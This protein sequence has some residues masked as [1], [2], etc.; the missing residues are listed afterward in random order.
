MDIRAYTLR[1][2]TDT[3]AKAPY[4]FRVIPNGVANTNDIVADLLKRIAGTDGRI[5]MIVGETLKVAIEHCR[6]GETVD[7]G[8][9]RMKPRITGSTPFEDSPFDSGLNEFIL[10]VYIDDEL[11]DTFDG[12]VPSVIS[13]REIGG[14]VKVSNVMD[15]GTQEFG[16]VRGTDPF[17]VLGNGV[18][19]DGDGESV[20]AISKKTGEEVGTASVVT[21]SK[22][23]RATC[24][25]DP[26]LPAGD[27]TFK[28]TTFGIAGDTTPHVFSKSVKALAVEPAPP[29]LTKLYPYPYEGEAAY[30][31]GLI[32]GA[33]FFLHGEN[34]T[35]VTELS[36]TYM[37][38]SD[39]M[40]HTKVIPAEGYEV[41]GGN[42]ITVNGSFWADGWGD[43]WDRVADVT[44]EVKTTKG[45]AT[46][47]AHDRS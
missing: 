27:Y 29:R 26:A 28:V 25:F 37:S 7:F 41:E 43:V 33:E 22:G 40:E 1:N 31:N 35:D 6:R 17:E 21:V 5:R 13:G 10:D 38:T 47:K 20:K 23:Q 34:L 4:N 32:E 19:L 45:S 12:I 14:L 39:G 30:E 24:R 16:V 15:I 11:R 46:L 2:A 8:A 9:F 36:F 42:R 3:G 44:F 18:T